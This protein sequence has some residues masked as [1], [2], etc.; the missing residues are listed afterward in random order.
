MLRECS[1]PPFDFSELLEKAVDYL[2][3][4]VWH[5]FDT[6]VV[7]LGLRLNYSER[8]S[9]MHCA[10][11]GE[12]T[13]WPRAAD[14]PTNFKGWFG[15]IWIGTDVGFPDISYSMSDSLNSIGLHTGTGGGGEYA[16]PDDIKAQL[17]YHDWPHWKAWG[18]DVKIWA[19]DWPEIILSDAITDRII[20]EYERKEFWYI[21]TS[22][23]KL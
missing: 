11:F 5:P 13:N 17:P 15:R 6:K 10:P 20:D 19:D 18:W 3:N 22:A 2:E 8:L 7:Y 16:L 23:I 12:R 21:R 4:V 9:A 1:P 14:R